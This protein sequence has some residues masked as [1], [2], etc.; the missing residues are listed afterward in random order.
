MRSPDLKVTGGEH[1]VGEKL[2]VDC[3]DRHPS[4]LLN[5]TVGD[6]MMVL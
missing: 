6:D 5:L 3:R 4:A 2:V 1:R